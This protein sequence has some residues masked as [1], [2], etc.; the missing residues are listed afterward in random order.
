MKNPLHCRLSKYDCGPTSMLNAM[1]FLFQRESRTIY[2]L[3]PIETR[4]AETC[5]L[6]RVAEQ[7]AQKPL[8]CVTGTLDIYTPSETHC[9]PLIR[10]IQAQGGTLLRSVSYPTDHFFADYRLT[11][12]E[13]VTAFLTGLLPVS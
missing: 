7:L 11:V 10:A 12:A 5:A 1:S 3:G 13:T 8:L 4:E 6:E 9:A 2:A